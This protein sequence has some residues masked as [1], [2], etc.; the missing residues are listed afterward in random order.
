[1]EAGDHVVVAKKHR[2]TVV[3]RWVG[4]SQL[5][6]KCRNKAIR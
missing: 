1:M 4:E 5:E 6:T 3:G 2:I